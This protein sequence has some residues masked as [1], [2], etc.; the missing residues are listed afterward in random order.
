[1][2]ARWPVTC[3]ASRYMLKECWP[4]RSMM[5]LLTILIRYVCPA[6]P[7]LSPI[8]VWYFDLGAPPERSDVKTV[9]VEFTR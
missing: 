5:R 3:F 9:D 2:V 4:S 7:A 6:R 8:Q 1:V